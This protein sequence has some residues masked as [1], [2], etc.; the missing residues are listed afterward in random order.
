MRTTT[1][2]KGDKKTINAWIFYD[3]A[4]SVYPLV[5]TTAIF[6]IY[7]EG[8]TEAIGG[9]IE[10][11]GYEFINTELI[12]YVGALSFLIV[13][14]VSPFLSGIADYAGH[15]K[16]FLKF[17]CYLGALSCIGLYFFDVEHPIFGLTC[18]L[19][20]SVGFWGSLVFYNSYLPEIAE[21][22][23]HDAISAKGFSMGY[24]GS[25]ILLLISLAITLGHESLGLA[26]GEAAKMSFILTGIWWI[27]FSQITYRRL[28]NVKTGVKVKGKLL[29][30]GYRELYKTFKGLEHTK[31]LKRYLR[32]FF[33]YS[34]GVQTVMLAAVYFAAKE[35]AWAEG[36]KTQGLIVSM[37][38]IQFLGVAGAQLLAKV[39]GKIGNLNA[40]KIVVGFW[41]ALCVVGYFVETPLQ[42]YIIAAFVGL[43]MGAI[44][45]LS[46]STYSKFLPPN[47]QDTASYF[48]FYDVSEKIGLIIGLFVFGYIEGITGSIRSSILALIVFFIIGFLLLM[49]VPK[50]ESVVDN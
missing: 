49:M 37:L 30:N 13:S 17:F 50:E 34:M 23:E 15:K 31:R 22:A 29:L 26:E 25:V 28:P 20:A 5:I 32:A 18:Y 7:Y 48:S 44:Q 2:V 9:K 21:P 35:V 3:W 39:S 1:I 12:N 36:E 33:V 19:F 8:A 11:F 4:N 38:L 43:V 40:L 10:V 41:A 24:I 16:T 6:P 27:G 14:I 47:T 42:F 45:A 46:R